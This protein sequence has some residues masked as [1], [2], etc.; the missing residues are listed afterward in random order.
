[1]LTIK[2]DKGTGIV[3]SVPSDSP[4]DYA[5]LRDLKN[6]PPLRYLQVF[7]ESVFHSFLNIFRIFKI[8]CREFC[9]LGFYDGVLLVGPHQGKKVQDVKKVIQKEM[10]EAAQAVVY[11]EPEKTIISRCV[12]FCHIFILSC[13]INAKILDL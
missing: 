5:A 4:D 1:M 12:M 8:I 2:E 13:F 10:I 11:M 6:K 7:C 3:T 9:V